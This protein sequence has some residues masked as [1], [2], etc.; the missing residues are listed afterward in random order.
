MTSPQARKGGAFERAVYTYLADQLGSCVVRPR[1][2]TADVGDI[3]I[4]PLLALELKNY[5]SLTR[6]CSEGL[7]Q[8]EAERAAAGL[9][10]GAVVLKRHGSTDPARSL[11]VQELGAAVQLW[12]EAL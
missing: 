5:S 10:H 6:G 12:R 11:V 9:P 4:H 8:I 3:H 2:T 7:A 1:V